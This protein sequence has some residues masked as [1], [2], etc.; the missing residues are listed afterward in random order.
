[1]QNRME[2]LINIQNSDC[3]Q[4]KGFYFLF[5]KISRVLFTIFVN[6]S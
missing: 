6:I 4:N 3:K 2:K 1:M 5:S